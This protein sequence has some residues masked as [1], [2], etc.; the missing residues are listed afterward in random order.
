MRLY[1]VNAI[2]IRRRN[3]SEKDRILTLFSQEQ[4][5]IEVLAKGARRPGSRHSYFS[6]IGSTG[7]F[8]I[9]RGKTLDLL[10]ETT[11]VFSPEEIRG[12]YHKTQLLGFM[13]KVIDKLF[14]FDVSYPKTYDVLRKAVEGLSKREDQLLFVSF[15]ANVVSDLGF[16][17]EL[18]NCIICHKKIIHEPKLFFSPKGGLIHCD[19]RDESSL[20]VQAN[21]IKLLRLLVDVPFLKISKAKINQKTFENLYQLLRLYFEWHFGKILPDKVS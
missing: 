20:K 21:E 1:K 12:R 18:Q 5:K 8:H 13:F 2:I 4:G 3:F 9:V 11:P 16:L 6:D 7:I 15:L 14:E 17:P 10:T 19:C